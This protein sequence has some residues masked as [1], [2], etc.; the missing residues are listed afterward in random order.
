MRNGFLLVH[1]WC[2]QKG[3]I[4][5][6]TLPYLNMTCHIQNN[7]IVSNHRNSNSAQ[8]CIIFP[9]KLNNLQDTVCLLGPADWWKSCATIGRT[10]ICMQNNINGCTEQSLLRK[11]GVNK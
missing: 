9:L 2:G 5:I 6:F 1:G 3:N 11:N 8:H 4:I 7:L 10:S